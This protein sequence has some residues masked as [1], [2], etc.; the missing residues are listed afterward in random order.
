MF[1]C[2]FGFNW[3]ET[4]FYY[5]YG[6]FMVLFYMLQI[7]SFTAY[8]IF[9]FSLMHYCRTDLLIVAEMIKNLASDSQKLADKEQLGAAFK[10]IISQHSLA[11][12]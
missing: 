11:L 1:N 4:W 7:S 9:K 6:V 10:D 8:T 12:R 5:A 2:S 3:K